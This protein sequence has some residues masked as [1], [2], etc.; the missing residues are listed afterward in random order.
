[1]KQELGKIKSR[2]ELRTALAA[3][4]ISVPPRIEGRQSHHVETYGAFRLLA[5]L[6]EHEWLAFPFSA[7]SGAEPPDYDL[8]SAENAIGLEITEAIATVKARF[9]ATWQ[10][11]YPD[12]MV[13]LGPNDL[14]PDSTSADFR[15]LIERDP[16][17]GDGWQ[18]DEPE[19]E[20]A[21]SVLKRCSE[22]HGKLARWGGNNDEKWLLIYMNE[23][24]PV[25]NIQRA[26]KHCRDRIDEFLDP[27]SA[28]ARIF[29]ED[30]SSLV[31][32]C[33]PRYVILPIADLW[34][35]Q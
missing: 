34:R 24:Y 32:F 6:N 35:H 4:D 7:N 31:C 20:W 15:R 29:V 21:A 30:D 13:S 28:F 17:Q 10:R 18:G 2:G 14:R 11:E 1:M 9:D 16:S 8:R 33:L 26:A 3:R 27:V 22:K 23:G 25:V 5:T 19:Q 12:T